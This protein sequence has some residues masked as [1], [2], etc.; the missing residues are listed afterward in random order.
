MT[1][2]DVTGR[3]GDRSVWKDCYVPG[4]LFAVSDLYVACVEKR[5]A[6]DAIVPDTDDDWLIVV[7]DVGEIFADI[8]AVLRLL[9]GRFRRVVWTPGKIELWTHP[10]DPVKL[11]GVARCKA[12][13]RLCRD[14]DVV[15]PEDEYP[16]WLAPDGPVV[17]APLFPLYDYSF[18]V[19]GAATKEEALKRAYDADV[20]CA[21]ESLLHP[22]PYRN[23]ESWRWAR[24]AAKARLSAID[25][26]L[27]TVLVSHWP[28]VWQP[29]DVLSYL[30][31]AQWCGT[32]LTV[33]WRIRFRAV[34]V[35]YGH[36]HIP[37]STAYGGVPFEQ[38]S[39]GYPRERMRRSSTPAP[40]R[41]ILKDTR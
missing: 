29:I 3:P 13:V 1:H 14:L 18:R 6:V 17:V 20:M 39:L 10:S 2:P 21:D 30:E 25:P 19:D 4:S 27:R 9:R 40:M 7:G 24:V 34:A 33:D 22:D 36:L 35:V 15:T 16:V 23:R 5:R 11:R 12:L 26:G 32:E 38:V 8:E 28:L 31:F 41:V 37:C